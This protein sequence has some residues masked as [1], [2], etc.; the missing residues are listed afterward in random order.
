MFVRFRRSGSRLQAS[1]IE[2]QRADGKVR[3]EHVASL[4]SIEDPPTVKERID[5]WRRLH[6]RIGQLS[7]RVDT[8]TQAKA[9]GAVHARVPMPT[10]EDIRALQLQNS[11]ANEKFWT[12]LRDI[13]Q[14]RAD[15]HK[16]LLA[17]IQQTIE[18]AEADAK[19]A[20]EKACDAGERASRLR[21][22]EDVVGGLGKQPIQED[23]ERILRDAGWTTRDIEHADVV[24]RLSKLGGFEEYLAEVH[25][26]HRLAEYAAARAILRRLT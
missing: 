18:T 9:L 8:A 17:T 19:A 11:E 12:G 20:A 1:L 7:N 13:R 23:L 22:G 10:I 25:K 24:R 2:T 5:F 15:D 26:R 6:E 3:Y 4:G 16:Q 21:A 14:A